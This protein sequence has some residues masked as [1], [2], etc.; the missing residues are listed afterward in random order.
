M[1]IRFFTIGG[2][3]D[4]I[5]PIADLDD[6]AFENEIADEIDVVDYLY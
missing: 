5:K 3:I 2:K 1:P 4:E 6:L